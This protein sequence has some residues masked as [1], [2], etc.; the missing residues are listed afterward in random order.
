MIVFRASLADCLYEKWLET[1]GG[2]NM[3]LSGIILATV[4]AF[5]VG[6]W[7][8]WVQAHHVVATECERLGKFFVGKK[9][10]SCIKIEEKE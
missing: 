5:I 1:K 8:G 10:Y 4:L 9:V 7:Y 6:K 3:S 2:F